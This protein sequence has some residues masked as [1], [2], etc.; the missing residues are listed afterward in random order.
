MN[1][2]PDLSPNVKTTF[3]AVAENRWASCPVKGPARG[4]AIGRLTQLG[5]ITKVREQAYTLTPAGEQAY[6]ANQYL[7][8]SQQHETAS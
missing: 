8:N 4:S 2:T 6:A 7:N 5:L 1:P 3:L